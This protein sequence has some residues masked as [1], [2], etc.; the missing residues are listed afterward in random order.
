[1]S[2]FRRNKKKKK[3]DDKKKQ[4]NEEEDENKKKKSINRM[5]RQRQRGNSMTQSKVH[6][7]IKKKSKC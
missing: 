4:K 7:Q 3:D 1:M 5:N 6:K 2:P